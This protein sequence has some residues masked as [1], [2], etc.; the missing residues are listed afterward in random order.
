MSRQERR[1]AWLNRE[2]W[3]ELRQYYRVYDHWKKGQPTQDYEDAVR[4]C[5]EK[6]RRTKAKLELNLAA[7]IKDNKNSFYKYINNKMRAKENL[8][9]LLDVGGNIVTRMRERLR[10]LVPSLPQS[11]TVRPVFLGVSSPLSW[12]IEAGSREKP[13]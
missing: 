13:L 2:L 8:R 12:K 1:P 9:P 10:Y 6:I 11:L 5:R 3:L 7:A 4:L